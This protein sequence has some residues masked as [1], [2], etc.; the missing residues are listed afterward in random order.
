MF[1]EKLSE[2]CGTED[3]DLLYRGSHD[4]FGTSDFHRQC[5]NKGK[6][7]ILVKNTSGHAFGGFA[8]VPWEGF[9]A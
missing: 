2:W 7:L 9:R 1:E 4:G 5:D 6:T 8:S 3:F